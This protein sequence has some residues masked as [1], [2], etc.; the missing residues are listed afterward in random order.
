MH[1]P[2]EDEGC[3]TEV[4]ADPPVDPRQ[5]SNAGWWLLLAG[6]IVILVIDYALQRS[7]RPTGSKKSQR[8]A[9]AHWW[10]RWIIGVVGVGIV[11]VWH[12]FW[13]I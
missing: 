12:M 1:Q 4:P 9:K 10:Y 6:L 11:F 13:G 8:Y 5:D 3:Y 2:C 7:G